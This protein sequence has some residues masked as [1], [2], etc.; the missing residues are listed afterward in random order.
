MQVVSKHLLNEPNV[1][2]DPKYH[3]YTHEGKHAPL[4]QRQTFSE[5]LVKNIQLLPD[6]FFCFAFSVFFFFSLSNLE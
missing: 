4:T 5:H 6:Y 3:L 1:A 2:L